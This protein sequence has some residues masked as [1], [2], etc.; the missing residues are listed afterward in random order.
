MDWEESKVHSKLAT[1]RVP[2]MISENW[3]IPQRKRK[4]SPLGIIGDPKICGCLLGESQTRESLCNMVRELTK[5]PVKQTPMEVTPPSS[6]VSQDLDKDIERDMDISL[7]EDEWEGIVMDISQNE[8]VSNQ[9]IS[10]S[11]TAMRTRACKKPRGGHVKIRMKFPA[12]KNMKRGAIDRYI[13]QIDKCHS[14]PPSI[15][16]SD[17][18]I[19]LSGVGKQHV[20]SLTLS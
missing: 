12:R 3:I 19:S 17:K 7:S 14:I 5:T 16:H 8:G 4:R 18:D 11:S 9:M 15:N 13:H 2:K 6:P 20:N 10:A 1:P